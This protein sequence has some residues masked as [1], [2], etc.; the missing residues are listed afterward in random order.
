MFTLRIFGVTG[1]PDTYFLCMIGNIC[2]CLQVK[3]PERHVDTLDLIY[4]ILLFKDGWQK[5]PAFEVFAIRFFCLLFI[6]FKR[7]DTVR[8]QRSVKLSLHNDF[9]AAVRAACST[10][11][12]LC[13]NLTAAG[14]AYIEHHL[15]FRFS[16]C[17][18]I[19]FCCISFLF[20]LFRFV[21]GICFF[22][23]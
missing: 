22:K 21:S 20:V 11:C 2:I 1:L 23:L 3:Y 9:V 6:L 18:L 14:L 17:S 16:F 4:M 5:F 10:C 8:L 19:S 13:Q 15:T 12:L 7:Y